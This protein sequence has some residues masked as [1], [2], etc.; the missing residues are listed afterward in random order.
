MSLSERFNLSDE[1]AELRLN[2]SHAVGHLE[3]FHSGIQRLRVGFE[4][5]LSSGNAN[6][7]FLC[8]VQSTVFSIISGEKELSA[9]LKEIDYY[10]HLLQ[11]YKSEMTRRFLLNSRETV[12]MLIDKGE[13]TSIEAKECPGDLDP[14]NKFLDTFYFHQAFRNY[15]LGF[16]ERCHHFAQK[17][18][19]TF[20]PGR[21]YGM[22]IRFY[23]GLNLLDSLKK[24][25][26]ASKRKE[27]H[28]AIAFMKVAVSHADSN[29]RNKL[30]LLEAEL[31]GL[32]ARHSLA[33]SSYDAAIASAKNSK[34]IHEQG[35]ACEKA[36]FY[37]KKIG[38]V[39]NASGYFQQARKCYEEWGSSVKVE[40]VQR[41][42]DGLSSRYQLTL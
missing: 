14:G 7:G 41:E 34:F 3:W 12:S 2:F 29:C 18:F 19:A 16:S 40:V 17:C 31:H 6:M 25:M 8:A 35:L 20:S 26:I 5:A 36:G 22:Q 13:A 27:V 38:D 37:Y 30:H 10:L 9:L 11:T 28:N 15:W 21:F 23:Y 39:G 33:V 24:K 4:S 42:L 32:D 1:M